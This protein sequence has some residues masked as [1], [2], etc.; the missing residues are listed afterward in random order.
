MVD[1]TCFSVTYLG[2]HEVQLAPSDDVL[3]DIIDILVD[4]P[5]ITPRKCV[6]EISSASVKIRGKNKD[7]YFIDPEW[8]ALSAVSEAQSA[9][10]IY[11][12]TL[13]GGKIHVFLSKSQA[14]SIHVLIDATFTSR[15][16][17]DVRTS[18]AF[19]EVPSRPTSRATSR[20]N[21]VASL[22]SDLPATATALSSRTNDS[23]YLYVEKAM[24]QQAAQQR[25]QDESQRSSVDSSASGLAQR[26]SLPQRPSVPVIVSKAPSFATS[27][28]TSAMSLNRARSGMSMLSALDGSHPGLSNMPARL[29]EDGLEELGEDGLPVSNSQSML[30][31]LWFRHT[32]RLAISDK[33]LVRNKKKLDHLIHAMKTAPSHSDV[34]AVFISSDD[35]IKVVEMSSRKLIS[36]E[37]VVNLVGWHITQVGEHDVLGMLYKDNGLNIC[38]CLVLRLL[39]GQRKACEQ[40]FGLLEAT[41]LEAQTENMV[42]LTVTTEDSPQEIAELPEFRELCSGDFGVTRERVEAVKPIASMM[43]EM[44]YEALLQPADASSEPLTVTA[45][46]LPPTTHGHR[47]CQV[48]YEVQLLQTLAHPNVLALA[49]VCVE[50]QPWLILREPS[51]FGPLNEVLLASSE[52]KIKLELE[53]K[54]HIARQVAD[55]LEYITSKDIV[56]IDIR[57]CNMTLHPN[58]IVKL[59]SFGV[60]RRVDPVKK[61]HEL[62]ETIRLPLRWMAPETMT[63]KKF[64]SASTDVWSFAVF[65]WEVFNCA[66]TPYGDLSLEQVYTQVP[67]GLRLNQRS[68]PTPCTKFLQKCWSAEPSERPSFTDAVTAFNQLMTDTDILRLKDVGKALGGTPVHAQERT[69]QGRSSLTRSQRRKSTKASVR[70]LTR[71]AFGTKGVKLAGLAE[72]QIEEVVEEKPEVVPEEREPD[73]EE[74]EEY[75]DIEFGNDTFAGARRV[76]NPVFQDNEMT[77][78]TDTDDE[79][80]TLAETKEPTPRG[81]ALWGHAKAKLGALDAFKGTGFK[82]DGLLSSTNDA[83]VEINIGTPQAKKRAPP[84]PAA[85]NNMPSAEEKVSTLALRQLQQYSMSSFDSLDLGGD[86]GMFASRSM[87]RIMEQTP[88]LVVAMEGESLVAE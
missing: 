47:L 79:Y 80:M 73:E 59:A 83:Y 26:P 27:K 55:A 51:G 70:R 45:T 6:V 87:E 50:E 11:E 69:F 24:Q 57:A 33:D 49:G 19:S 15:Q 31:E 3:D 82:T 7:D 68:C 36:L 71:T 30:H 14:T 40:L 52:K 22:P 12:T 41:A 85:G 53:G 2:F 29:D 38:R 63:E 23:S 75:L 34:G 25:Q 67:E 88:E 39:N 66:A 28:K 60:A 76:V 46:S 5:A 8:L 20:A 72:E 65:I 54:Y 62:Q 86:L 48:L 64:F 4:E 21:S 37:P 42:D 10:A 43:D 74:E 35:K 16:N 44:T 1:R 18:F 17:K 56:V 61:N 58:L 32:A 9:T 81:K 77:D 84:P 13:S 78:D